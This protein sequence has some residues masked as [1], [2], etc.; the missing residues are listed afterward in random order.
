M[1]TRTDPGSVG[2]LVPRLNG[3]GDCSDR[4]AK[5]RRWVEQKSNTRLTLVGKSAI[6][7][8]SMRGNIENPIGAAQIPLGI[9]GPLMIHGQH[10]KGTFYVPL[11]T[12]EGALVRSYERGMVA[13]TRAGGAT[14][15]VVSAA[16]S[17]APVFKCSDIA[18]AVE[19]CRFVERHALEIRRQADSTTSHGLL[20]TVSPRLI[21]REVVVNL[22]FHTGDAHG[23]NMIA[24]ATSVACAWIASQH[25]VEKWYVLSGA[26]SEK[27]ASA[28]LLAGGK[29]QYA[30]AE[31]KLSA[32][33]CNLYLHATPEQL[34]DLWRRT[35]VAQSLGGAV[36]YNGHYANGLTALFIATGQDVANVVNSAVGFTNLEL[37]SESNQQ[38]L[39]ISVVLPS[40]TLATVGGGTHL[41]TAAECLNLLSCLGSKRVGRFAEITAAT[42]LAGELSFAAA[43]AS[44]E[45]VEAHEQYG[46][47]RPPVPTAE[48][49]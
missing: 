31:A 45:F 46:R 21:G 1:S 15:R 39:Y 36:G 43:L 12:T 25:P 7:C 5:R 9:A 16:N 11:A 14:S 49:I 23:M 44:D 28:G 2:D 3:T 34:V 32:R 42:V 17:S 26:S 20:Q 48:L 8:E 10:A 47:N 24:N 33:I 27:R 40:L 6:P 29:G 18:A 19:L 37:R 38:W 22:R 13:I 4:V 41:G 35:L 30:V